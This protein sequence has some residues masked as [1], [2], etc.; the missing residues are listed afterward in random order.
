V[1]FFY[2]GPVS[3]AMAFEKLLRSA[4]A[5][6]ERLALLPEPAAPGPQLVSV[7][8]DGETFGHHEPF[9]DMCIAS[10]CNDK[11][12]ARGFRL[13]NYAELLEDLKPT[14]EV[15][16]HSGDGGEGTA[17]SCAHGVGRWVRDCGCSTGAPPGWNQAWRLPLR[18]A[19]D[20]LRDRAA[21]LFETHGGKLLHDPWQARD[22]Y[23][24]VVTRPDDAAVLEGFLARHLRPGAGPAQRDAARTLLEA[25]RHAMAMYTSCGWF[26]ADI[27]GIETVQNL[28]YAARCVELMRDISGQDLEGELLHDLAAARSNNGTDTG[29][30][31]YRRWVLPDLRS[32]EHAVTARALLGALNLRRE[33]RRIYAFSVGAADEQPVVLAGHGGRAGHLELREDRTGR[34]GGYS[35]V[36]LQY[37]PRLLACF[38]TPADRSRHEQLGRELKRLRADLT[39]LE[40]ER[41]LAAL[42][43]GPPRGIGD[44]LPDERRRIASTLASERVSAMRCHARAVFDESIELLRDFAAMNLE[45]PDELRLPCELSLQADVEAA[46]AALRPP[47]DPEA[48]QRLRDILEQAVQLRLRL[49]LEPVAAV[50]SAHLEEQS[51]RLRQQPDR[52]AFTAVGRLLDLTES[53]RLRVD[54]TEAEEQVHALVEELVAALAAPSADPGQAKLLEAALQLAV[55]LN[56]AADEVRWR[57]Q[58]PGG[59]VPQQS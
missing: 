1:V 53:L 22:D 36:A 38:V 55:R 16:L 58:V 44:L 42:Y 7:A 34:G 4:D 52:F 51:R 50:V 56:F 12:G 9:G 57:L 35:Y 24:D 59:G 39:R 10:F 32:A 54:R 6:A 41:V 21:A 43:S 3:Q 46:A 45:L 5:L 27:T 2:D 11:A 28:R 15:E 31:I 17:W 18:R 25:Q 30:S 20:G 40:L 49:R 13:T 33:S 14:H 47:F 37:A 23:V 8:V 29:A 19:L 26:F 48:T